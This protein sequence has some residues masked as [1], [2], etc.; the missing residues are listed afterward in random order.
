ML[1]SSVCGS[2][3]KNAPARDLILFLCLFS[4]LVKSQVTENSA[5]LPG[6]D[7]TTKSL[8]DG[9]EFKA[10]EL[11]LN[12][13]SHIM[14]DLTDV[15][16]TSE[17][18]THYTTA[19][20]SAWHQSD[21]GNSVTKNS[22]NNFETSPNSIRCGKE[23]CS[24]DIFRQLKG[25]QGEKG[26]MGPPGIPGEMGQCP[27]PTCS[28]PQILY[29]KGRVGLKGYCVASCPASD[30]GP[31]GLQGEKGDPGSDNVINSQDLRKEVER[32][33]DSAIVQVSAR[34]WTNNHK[35]L[36]DRKIR[37]R[38]RRSLVP[39]FGEPEL[40]VN[41][42]RKALG[43][44]IL[45]DVN[46]L[47]TRGDNLPLGAIVATYLYESFRHTGNPPPM[48][49][50]VK[51]DTTTNRWNRVP[52]T[53]EKEV[54]YATPPSEAVESN[55]PSSQLQLVLAFYP[56]PVNGAEFLGWYGADTLCRETAERRLGVP[57]FRTFLSDRNLPI[58][59]ILPWRLIRVPV[60]NL[61]GSLLFRELKDFLYGMTP[62]SREPLYDLNGT[63]Y[64]SGLKRS[65]IYGLSCDNHLNGITEMP[66]VSQ[67]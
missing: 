60:I 47:K 56:Y 66:I 67:L 46:E 55:L 41:S 18:T 3:G 52:V 62:H 7:S 23:L 57:G 61:A 8:L 17:Q 26:R 42:Q 54:T 39:Q 34:N 1:V 37:I 16:F 31:M 59:Q 4:V 24:P 64:T 11:T 38:R 35:E 27:I 65:V 14:A 53:F 36:K 5:Q 15:T 21:N 51:T 50:F 45:N 6:T 20:E 9:S 10:T 58:E 30:P 22:E 29:E 12:E 40:G 25:P 43:L 63:P 49:M 32:I 28:Q 48:G 33:I 13:P 19:T 2:S 44:L